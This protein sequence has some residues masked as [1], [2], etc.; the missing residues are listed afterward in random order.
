[1]GYLG[2]CDKT[3]AAMRCHLQLLHDFRRFATGGPDVES[4]RKR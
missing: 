3:F 1:M 4:W 2:E